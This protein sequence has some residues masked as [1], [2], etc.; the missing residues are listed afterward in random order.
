MF[1][2]KKLAADSSRCT[3]CGACENVCS[4]TW[5][6]LEDREKSAIQISADEQGGYAIAVCDQCGEC[7]NM[8]S[9]LALQRANNGVVRLDKKSCV[10]CL[11]CVGECARGFMRYHDDLPVSFKCVA[12]GLCA[13][14]CPSGALKIVEV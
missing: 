14:Q 2:L 3:G 5:H 12:C 8:C 13:Q 11:V 4:K 7:M 6:K 1:D 10:G 9:R